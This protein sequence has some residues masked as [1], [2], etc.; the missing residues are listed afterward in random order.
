MNETNCNSK[1]KSES[2]S[3]DKDVYDLAAAGDLSPKHKRKRILGKCSNTVI[4]ANSKH[5]CFVNGRNEAEAKCKV[6][7]SYIKI[8]SRGSAAL[9]DHVASVASVKHINA[10]KTAS[11]CNKLEKFFPNTSQKKEE[12]LQINMKVAAAEITLCYHTIKHHQSYR[13]MDCT[14]KLP[15]ILFG[16]SHAAK[17]VK[18][19]RT[20]T[21]AIV[22]QV[23]YPY[24]RNQLIQKLQTVC[25]FSVAT[26]ASNHKVLKIFPVAVQ[27]FDASE[28]RIV[29]RVL[30]I[31]NLPNEESETIAQYILQILNHDNIASK[32]MALSADNTNTNFGG[33]HRR[34]QKNVFSKLKN[35][36]NNSS[37]I[38]V[39]CPA[40]IL[41]NCISYGTNTLKVDIEF[42]VTR[43]YY[44]FWIYTV[45]CEKLKEFCDFVN[46]E[47]SAMLKHSKSR[48]LSLFPAVERIL[49]MFAALKSYFLSQDST[50]A[51]AA[52]VNFFS[53]DFSECYLYFIH[54][55]SA[56]FQRNISSIEKEK[57]SVIE[58]YDI[59]NAVLFTLCDQREN[60]FIPLEIRKMLRDLTEDGHENE[61][62]KFREEMHT[63][64]NRCI[65]YLN[66][67]LEP[68]NE[69]KHFHWLKFSYILEKDLRYE[70]ILD[71]I[72]YLQ[73]KNVQFD[74]S[75]LFNQFSTLLKRFLKEDPRV[76]KILKIQTI[77]EQWATYFNFC[78]N[79]KEL[80]SELLK[81][82]KFYFAIP[83]HNAALERIFSLF[84][85]RS[86]N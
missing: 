55:I 40:H 14:S 54:S 37:L 61:C 21:Q 22:N 81:V 20:K 4:I 39:G 13:S 9:N 15:K 30:K 65:E 42:I 17:N 16:D 76:E 78:I 86:R 36:L 79:A 19:A 45:R 83:S 56:I 50:A 52:L 68:F 66:M 69:F 85:L 59:L 27:Y 75:K 32:C 77:D 1:S 2:E 8:S 84:I 29:R 53:N 23:L 51:P 60:N 58:V 57:S 46:T 80:C 73:S 24:F 25:W 6:C 67:W 64:Y 12:L 34:G 33:L 47:Y 70:E 72:E 35:L 26:D 43:L 44:Y 7:D 49:K 11:S 62:N 28:N 5:R 3:E 63:A 38:G 18:C 48:W 41:H 82:A 74:D 31:E 10:L 71:S